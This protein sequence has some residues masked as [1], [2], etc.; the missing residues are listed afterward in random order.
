VSFGRSGGSVIWQNLN[1][2]SEGYVVLICRADGHMISSIHIDIAASPLPLKKV[3]SGVFYAFDEGSVVTV[4]N[5][6]L[7]VNVL[8]YRMSTT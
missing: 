2:I 3:N 4:T 5:M 1:N 6:K 8:N 7:G